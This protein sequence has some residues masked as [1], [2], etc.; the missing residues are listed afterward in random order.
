MSDESE[1]VD[2]PSGLQ[3]DSGHALHEGAGNDRLTMTEAARLKGVS[4]HTVSR[5]VRRG[6]LPVVR[7]GRMALISTRDLQVW[8]PMKERAPHKYRRESEAFDSSS[9][10][11]L[12]GQDH[13]A[14]VQR[15]TMLYEVIHT[16][17][18]ECSLEDLG[19]VATE[20]IAEAF[21]LSRLTLWQ[22][23]MASYTARRLA[24]VHEKLSDVPDVVSLDRVPFFPS[25]ISGSTTRIIREIDAVVRPNDMDE[26]HIPQGPVVAIPLIWNERIVGVMYGDCNG[27]DFDLNEE[28]LALADG[29]ASQLAM[30]IDSATLR[31]AERRRSRQLEALLE[32]TVSAVSAFDQNGYLT[33]TNAS[34]RKLFDLSEDE[35]CI[36]QHVSEYLRHK[37][38][39]SL[40]GS[41]VGVE[42]NPIER[43]LRGE[44]SQN[45]EQVA[46]RKDGE[47]RYISTN[48][49]PIT[50]DG[51]I[52]G[53][54]S[55]SRDITAER[56]AEVQNRE[57]LRQTQLAAR[58]SQSLA[59]IVVE[60]NSDLD[61]EAVT[62]A[63]L[64]RIAEEFQADRGAL[65][66]R[67]DRGRFVVASA[68]NL[69]RVHFPD[70]GIAPSSMSL[71]KVAF[72]RNRPVL[73]HGDALDSLRDETGEFLDVNAVLVIPM[74]IR[75]QHVGVAYLTFPDVPEMD[76]DDFGFA[77]VWGRQCAQA[78]DRARLINQLEYAHGR[79]MATI[80]Q[81]PQAV[82]IID[83]PSGE[84]TMANETAKELWGPS[85]EEGRVPA[86]ALRVLDAEGAPFEE[87]DHPF[88]RPL[89][90]GEP[91]LGEPLTVVKLDRSEVEM[92][93]NQSPIFDG[94]G[95]LV[96]AV[97]VLQNRSDFKPLDRAKDEF[98]SVVA[99]ELR[100]PLT[101]LRGNLQLLQRRIRRRGDEHAEEEAERLGTV[102]TQVDRI[103]D[104]V[105]RMLD[106]SRVDLG[107]LDVSVGETDAAM[108]VHTVVNEA[109]GLLP[110]R[111]IML[112]GPDT[113]P[114]VWDAARVQQ[115]LANLM[116]N[117]ER[118]APDGPV[119]V[120][121]FVTDESRVG[122]SV[123]DH[124]PG[125]PPKIRKRLFKQYYRFD[126]GHDENPEAP[127]D[128]NHGLGIGLY[129]S[130]RLAR[131][132]GGSLTVDD[133]EGGGAIF[134]LDLPM[135][136][137]AEGS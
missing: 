103:A 125:V 109:Q 35:A 30:A 31:Q 15:L 67:N 127:T 48:T 49:R 38:R 90:T 45:E 37:R 34:E 70:D 42:N 73:M 9:S 52:V 43:A 84:V 112:S 102:I 87:A 121:L 36:G 81:L 62:R 136:A 79:L 13:V 3:D 60:M 91:S 75:G 133:A 17:A 72:R 32:E 117:A 2:Q 129:I 41:P 5:A 132:H 101:S 82:L 23:D 27:K 18:S 94:R 95:T 7:L 40:D 93:G 20:R 51:E 111:T 124:G 123:R 50:V 99:H 12:V 85:L 105:S 86:N 78:I 65:L 83:Y 114:V 14:L 98:I 8:R 134:T 97:S 63:A 80:D 122:I 16:A 130:A 64:Y 53:S 61:S 119:E 69:E 71:A 56:E 4:Y 120:N 28:E 24:V 104:L 55:V 74:Q 25:L 21:Q 46:I 68:R 89:R 110:H 19:Q 107:S 76:D 108:L 1:R 128:S 11:N 116:Q 59:D 54:V 118:Y 22:L 113:L 47:R 126:D 106:V 66:L 10:V 29:V 92:L 135:N 131:A 96:G 39:E 100:N 115:I 26:F 6:S 137:S 77:G 33:L 57:Y 44:R 58:R 88:L